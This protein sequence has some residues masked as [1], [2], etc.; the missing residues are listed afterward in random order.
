MS[1]RRPSLGALLLA[2]A[3]GLAAC[4]GPPA[5]GSPARENPTPE[6]AS[7]LGVADLQALPQDPAF[8]LAQPGGRS[9]T[10]DPAQQREL[11]RRFRQEFFAPWQ[12]EAPSQDAGQVRQGFL[13][14]LEGLGFG[15][16]RWPH[17]P[18]WLQGLLDYAGLED[19]PNQGYAGLSL[20]P[21]D[22]RSLPSGRPHLDGFAH[23]GQGY[24]FDNLQQSLLPPNT[25][26]YVVHACRDGAWLLCDTPHGLWWIKA[27]K[28]GRADTDLRR[29]WMAAPLA[30]LTAEP[31][32]LKD[33]RGVYLFSVGVGALFPL[34]EQGPRGLTLLAAVGQD[35]RA[36]PRRVRLGPGQAQ[37]WPLAL[38]SAAVA[39]QAAALLG[40]P[41]GWG[42]SFGNRDCSALLK[43][44]FTPFGLWLPRNS[45]E[46]A[47]EVGQFLPLGDLEPREREKMIL[48]RGVPFLS[49][50]WRPGHIMLYIGARQ[51]RAMVLH[52]L[53]GLKT[54]DGQGREGRHVVGRSVIT[55]LYAGQE[56]PDL[57]RPEGLLLERVEG[58]TLLAPVQSLRWSEPAHGQPQGQP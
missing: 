12:Q 18:A 7:A 31:V 25:P 13:D 26:L 53:W 43:D 42:G 51:G 40:Q 14:F 10:L 56:L 33:G 54:R 34:V 24:A 1:S 41:Y 50:V 21:A 11:A 57:A 5:P 17:D 29:A 48:E 58:L 27:D 37:A 9:W 32:A 28:V 22:L 20:G 4:Q 44:I 30:A 47:R 15:E 52:G 38:S 6:A 45:R 39:R 49:L 35:G 19:Y 55:S 23:A 3:L 8:Y 36:R 2:L 46:Q 16:D